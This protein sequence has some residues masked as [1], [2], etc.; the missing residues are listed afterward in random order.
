MKS[1]LSYK[2][3]PRRVTQLA[4]GVLG[5]ALAVSAQ[6]Q[7]SVSPPSLPWT[8][9]TWV[10]V[11]VSNV[12][13]GAEVDLR[14]YVDVDGDGALSGVDQLVASFRVQDGVTNS[15][16]SSLI[17]DDMDHATN[18]II[19]SRIA[20]FHQEG[21]ESP[22]HIVGNYLWAASPVVGDTAT[23]RFAVTQP[24]ST[25]WVTGSVIDYVTSNAIPGAIVELATA[26]DVGNLASWT[27]TNGEFMIYVPTGLSTADVD[28][29]TAG[30]VGYIT[31][32]DPVTG[33]SIAEY[34]FSAD[35]NDGNNPLSTTLRLVPVF[36]NQVFSVSGYL[37]SLI[38]I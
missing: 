33:G 11:V 8:S 28:G 12:T 32:D 1:H 4:A 34:S 26:V 30:G 9:N 15:L 22:I 10:N 3:Y 5:L 2:M 21:M 17:V 13:V 31:S 19:A 36:S 27:D 18:G 24:T 14:L 7:V 37:L 6:I 25:V 38:H 16:G 20:Y 29:V 23:A 35:L